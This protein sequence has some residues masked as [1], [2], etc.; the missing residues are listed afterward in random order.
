MRV[1]ELLGFAVTDLGEDDRGEVGG[2]GG[3]GGGGGMF[4]EHS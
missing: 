4:G 1:D 2:A 3:C